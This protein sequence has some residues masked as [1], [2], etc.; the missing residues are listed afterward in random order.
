MSTRGTWATSLTPDLRAKGKR[1]MTTM[2][3]AVPDTDVS[4]VPVQLTCVHELEIPTHLAGK[5][6][7]ELVVHLAEQGV[8]PLALNWHIMN[9]VDQRP[10]CM[11]IINPRPVVT[12]RASDSVIV[13][14]KERM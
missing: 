3:T 2:T 8:V 13:L 10:F 11:T 5:S 7:R 6:Y 1:K 14:T 4:P 12:L 9:L